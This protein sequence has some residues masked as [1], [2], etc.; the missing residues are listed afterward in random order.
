ML[1]LSVL[2]VQ[3]EKDLGVL[4]FFFLMIMTRRCNNKHTYFVIVLARLDSQKN[5]V[6]SQCQPTRLK[7]K[8]TEKYFVFPSLFQK[9]RILMVVQKVH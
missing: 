8:P 9:L 4:G 5:I 7:E 2:K 6:K 1:P 3:N